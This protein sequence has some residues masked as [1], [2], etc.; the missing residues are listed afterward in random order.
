MIPQLVILGAGA[1]VFVLV[2]WWDGSLS[3]WNEERKRRR[4]WRLLDRYLR[5]AGVAAR[6][7][8]ATA[9]QATHALGSL[10]YSIPQPGRWPDGVP[11][12]DR[13]IFVRLGCGHER[14]SR[15][16]RGEVGDTYCCDACHQLTFMEVVEPSSS[17]F[18]TDWQVRLIVDEGLHAYEDGRDG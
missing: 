2:A 3:R 13:L 5:R 14:T 16:W 9:D 4:M 17:P 18:P 7:M 8:S 11:V 15:G 6:A 10:H 1:L 12:H